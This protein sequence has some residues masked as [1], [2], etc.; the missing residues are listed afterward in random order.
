LEMGP[1]DKQ[2]LR[3]Q[4]IEFLNYSHSQTTGETKPYVELIP[5]ME[6]FEAISDSLPEGER[7]KLLKKIE[8]FETRDTS[9]EVSVLTHKDIAP[10][11]VLYDKKSQTFSIIDF[12]CMGEDNIYRDFQFAPT[13]SYDDLWL[14]IDDYNKTSDHK[15][16]PEKVKMFKELNVVTMAYMRSRCGE[17]ENVPAIMQK[18]LSEFNQS[19]KEH[20]QKSVLD[21]S[22][23][24]GVGT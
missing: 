16:N 13:G 11:N 17:K 5:Y 18:S 3:E 19:Y 22:E 24:F 10:D 6:C 9:D 1:E 12:E 20:Y 23:G 4:L 21:G 14:M 8:A 7:Q 15:V 2:K